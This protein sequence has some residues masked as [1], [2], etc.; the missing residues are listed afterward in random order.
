M[1]NP[2]QNCAAGWLALFMF[3]LFVGPSISEDVPAV[4][5]FV[6]FHCTLAFS[7]EATGPTTKL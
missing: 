7:A 5:V 4:V 2:S 3:E 6:V 1:V